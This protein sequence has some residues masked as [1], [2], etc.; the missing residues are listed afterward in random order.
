MD[1][2]QSVFKQF[3]NLFSA[4][5]KNDINLVKTI[6]SDLNNANVYETLGRYYTENELY[7]PLSA[8]IRLGNC[9]IAKLLFNYKATVKCYNVN[10]NDLLIDSITKDNL[11]MVALLLKHEADHVPFK[12]AIVNNIIFNVGS[13]SMAELLIQHG[14]NVNAIRNHEENT[15]AHTFWSDCV[16]FDLCEFLLK[17]E[18]DLSVKNRNGLTALEYCQNILF[19]DNP[20]LK[21]IQHYKLRKEKIIILLLAF[22]FDENSLVSKEHIGKDMFLLIMDSLK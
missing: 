2:I 13:K 15:I 22:M 12:N 9:K 1:D 3:S 18:I 10:N 11:P 14:A 19:S 8:A 21:L 20:K 7:L 5:A 4:V 6:L 17:K 16:P